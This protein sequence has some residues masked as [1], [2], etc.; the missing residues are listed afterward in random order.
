MQGY[1]ILFDVAR[2]LRG[3]PAVESV[4]PTT[5]TRALAERQPIVCVINHDRGKVLA[6]TA[7]GSLELRLERVGVR[8]A[9]DILDTPAGNELLAA[10]ASGRV[11]GGSFAFGLTHGAVFRWHVR[12]TPWRR[13][14]VAALVDE[15]TL[16][17]APS[18]PAFAD[19][20]SGSVMLSPEMRRRFARLDQHS[21]SRY[22]EKAPPPAD[23]VLTLPAGRVLFPQ[24]GDPR[25]ARE[26]KAVTRAVE[27]SR[28]DLS[29]IDVRYGRT[30][31]ST[32]AVQRRRAR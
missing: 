30:V 12:E 22:L 11:S 19:T 20:W 31:A 28:R 4:A 3:L 7:D 10:W 5:L 6:S 17:T 8:S 23:L 29:T 16:T 18:R 24:I 15:L 25:P 2:P 13:E 9:F 32:L 26:Y 14:I 21:G 27:S 1:S